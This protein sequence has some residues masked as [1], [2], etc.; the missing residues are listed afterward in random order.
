MAGKTYTLE[1]A[2]NKLGKSPEEFKEFAKLNNIS[3]LRDG[4]NIL[5]D[6]DGV[7]TLAISGSDDTVLSIE[8]SVIGLNDESSLLGLASLDESDDEFEIDA[9]MSS[10]VELTEADTRGGLTGISEDSVVDGDDSILSLADSVT[11]E[12]ETQINADADIDTAS[13]D[14]SGS[15]LLD[16]SL[17]AD[18]SQFGAVLDDILPGGDGGFDDFSDNVP[19]SGDDFSDGSSDSDDYLADTSYDSEPA[20]KAPVST[21]E[22]VVAA[23]VAA[24][25][26][27]VA[28]QTA[29]TDSEG[30]A[31]GVMML[32]PLLALIFAAI[33][34][35]AGFKSVTPSI[36]T[37]IEDYILYVFGGLAALAVIIGV[38]GAVAGGEKKAKP[39]K[40]AKVQ[41]AKKVKAPKKKKK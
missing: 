10:M 28:Y 8:D 19:S 1:Q 22:P 40:P 12:P 13:A 36:L 26:Q 11:D 23:P 41:K 17:Q 6:A 3:E 25:S 4:T 9:D 14:G 34:I 24:V 37:P 32:L 15:G 16:L 31:F 2:A 38:V 18:D 7:D 35:V 27:Q 39:A 30:G 20:D 5:Y 29:S 21:P 33:V